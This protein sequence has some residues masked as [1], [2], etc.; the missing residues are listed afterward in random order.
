[1]HIQPP[2]SLS[3]AGLLQ[4]HSLEGR[5]HRQ[6]GSSGGCWENSWVNMHSMGRSVG[7]CSESSWRILGPGCSLPPCPKGY[8]WVVECAKFLAD[9]IVRNQTRVKSAPTK[10]VALAPHSRADCQPSLHKCTVSHVQ[11]R[12][13]MLKTEE[14]TRRPSLAHSTSAMNIEL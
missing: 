11:E 10:P 12:A 3:G 1:V 9:S 8:A 2:D 13:S 5:E 6:S 7:C 14:Y 4:Q